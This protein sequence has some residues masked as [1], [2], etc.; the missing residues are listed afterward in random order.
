VKLG[1]V[2]SSRGLGD[3]LLMAISAF[4]LYK[5]GYEVYLFNDEKF[6]E[7][8]R[9]F[10]WLKIAKF[11]TNEEELYKFD[12]IIVQ[13]DNSNKIAKLAKFRDLR[14]AKL[15]IFYTAHKPSKNPP[16]TVQDFVFNPTI[17]MVENIAISSAKL[18]NLEISTENGIVAP[19]GL[20]HRNY[21][22]KII[23]QPTSSTP[24]RSWPKHKFLKLSQMLIDK[25]YKVSC[26]TSYKER[27]DWLFLQES[28][29]EVPIL[30][31]VED[32]SALIY[33]SSLFI[34]NESVGGHL[35]SCLSIT[36]IT[37]GKSEKQF[38]LWRP[39]WLKG[40]IVCPPAYIPNIKYC[41]LRENKW[42]YFISPSKVLKVLNNLNLTIK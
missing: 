21:P 23:I 12:Q 30:P 1:A 26:G 37:I 35:A 42:Q 13:N 31:S 6:Q 9:W 16:L 14:K 36:T 24:D 38:R 40:E 22:N 28:G 17:S 5:Q 25:G 19:K 27:N 39:S 11:P 2:I 18:L 8:Q 4:A 41:R 34:G 3:G 20:I 7:L 29:V 33:E 10:P 15:S 32:F